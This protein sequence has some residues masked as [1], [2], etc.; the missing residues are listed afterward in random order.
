MKSINTIS[1]LKRWDRDKLEMDKIK[2]M[3]KIKHTLFDY[4]HHRIRSLRKSHTSQ[5]LSWYKQ[6]WGK[7]IGQHYY[8]KITRVVI[9]D[10]DKIITELHKEYLRVKSLRNKDFKTMFSHK[11]PKIMI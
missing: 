10:L 2:E 5:K 3:Y 11:K 8:N 7:E 4:I 9:G 6:S 1:L